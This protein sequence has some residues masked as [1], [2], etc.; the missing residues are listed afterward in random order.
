MG[1]TEAS[2]L[3]EEIRRTSE[4]LIVGVETLEPEVQELAIQEARE[5]LLDEL[6]SAID[7][8]PEFQNPILKERLVNYFLRPERITLEGDKI[9][10]NVDL[11]AN[12]DWINAQQIANEIRDAGDTRELTPAQRAA[13]WRYKVYGTDDYERTIQERFAALDDTEAAPY[14]FFLE[15]GTGPLAH[16]SSAGTFFIRRTGVRT[17]GLVRHWTQRVA[18]EFSKRA[19]EGL[20]QGSAIAWTKWSQGKTG[21]WYSYAYNPRTGWR[22]G[23][24][25]ARIRETM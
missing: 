24:F 7:R 10:I 25:K 18:D 9:R 22:L 4:Q 6:N 20:S 16:P 19:A 15:F 21:K 2:E 23:G 8:T 11:N 14:W 17:K 13:Y 1:F 3:F 12:K 5:L